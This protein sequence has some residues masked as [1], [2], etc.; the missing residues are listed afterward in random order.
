MVLPYNI[1]ERW[2]KKLHRVFVSKYMPL[3]AISSF[4]PKTTLHNIWAL[5]TLIHRE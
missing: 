4:L 1:A 5:Y 3:N 2:L